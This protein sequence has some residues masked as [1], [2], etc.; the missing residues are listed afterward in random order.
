M[1]STTKRHQS[2][3]PAH[4]SSAG[5]VGTY[6]RHCTL[7]VDSSC[8]RRRAP[9]VKLSAQN[10]MYLQYIHPSGVLDSNREEGRIPSTSSNRT[11][12]VVRY[13]RWNNGDRSLRGF[14]ER[15]KEHEC[16]KQGRGGKRP[17]SKKHVR[18]IHGRRKQSL[19]SPW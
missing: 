4:P 6:W 17:S 15:K 14:F 5:N 3:Q 7:Q 11:L 18:C 19:S 9:A 8:H 13:H 16:T 1:L 12:A 10:S 2:R